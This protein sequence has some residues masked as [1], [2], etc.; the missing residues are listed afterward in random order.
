[1][2]HLRKTLPALFVAAA[3]GVT[4][5][6]QAG[7]ATG[8]ATQAQA[9]A[10]NASAQVAWGRQLLGSKD[11]ATRDSSA[12]WFR[13]AAEQGDHDGEWMLGSAYLGGVGVARDAR[14]GLEW[15]RKSIADGS[16]DHMATYGFTLVTM[17]V[18]DGGKN[19]GVVWLQRAA[20]AGSPAGML[21]IGTFKVTGAMGV[22]KDPATGEKLIR[23]AADKG[24][25]DAQASLGSLYLTD[26]L[27]TPK[28]TEAVRWLEMAAAQGNAGAQGEVAYMLITGDRGVTADPA[29][30]VMWAQKA[31]AQNEPVGYYALG[32]AYLHGAGERKD[33]A[34]AWYNFG[35]AARLDTKHQFSKVANYMS[36]AATQLNAGD[37]ERLRARVEK[38]PLPGSQQG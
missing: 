26:M 9:E 4:A 29:R 6:A 16:P 28:P 32:H 21:A 3:L 19:D 27:G 18:F 36:E 25:A 10:G 38:I 34:E 12:T 23:A 5:V 7:D 17:G 33:P 24:F 31:V 35:V 11:K 37:L 2:R 20:D 22:P 13:K 14:L 15:M 1:M 30:G 8:N